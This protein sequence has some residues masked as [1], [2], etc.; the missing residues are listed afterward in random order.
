MAILSGLSA[1]HCYDLC[2]V[3]TGPVG[4]SMALEARARGAR[5]LLLE[6]GTSE[7]DDTGQEHVRAHIADAQRHAPMEIATQRGLGGGSWLWGGRCVPFEPID[8]APRDFVPGSGW[9][10]GL[11]ELLPWYPAAAQFLDCSKALFRS[12]SDWPA[13]PEI[14]LSQLE[15]WS[16]QPKLAPKLGGWALATPG[17]DILCDATV[18]GLDL[19]PQADGG[20]HLRGLQV[21]HVDQAIEVH[22]GDYVLA[23]GGLETTRLLLA[24]QARRAQDMPGLFGGQGGPLGGYY[25]GHIFG[26]IGSLVLTKPKSFTALDFSLDQT[27]TYVR[28]R[29]TL[30]ERVQRERQLLNTSFFADNPPFYDERHRNPTLSLVFLALSVP[31]LGRRLLSEAIRLKHIG[32]PP[33]R[34]GAHMLNVLRRPWRAV[35][36]VFD[37]LHLRYLS[38]TRKPGFVLRNEGG[39][40][41]LNYHAE[42]LPNPDSRVTLAKQQDAYGR[43]RLHID[44]RY[45]PADAESV[46]R[47]HEVLD[48]NLRAAGM[49]H[50]AY[51]RPPEQRLDHILEQASD[52]FHQTGTTRMSADPG[53]GVVDR[54]GAVH[55]VAHL[56]VASSSNFP[57]TGEA[58]PTFLAVAMGVRLAARLA[59]GAQERSAIPSFYPFP[60]PTSGQDNPPIPPMKKITIPGTVLAVSRFSFGTASLHHLF[61]QEQRLALLRA[62]I[63]AGFTHFDTSPYYGFGLAEQSLGQLS[64]SELQGITIATKVGLYGPSGSSPQVPDILLRKVAGKFIKS[65]NQPVVDWSLAR[66]RASLEQS[67][68]R[69]R[70]GHVDILY[71][72]E[73]VAELIASDEWQRWLESLVLAGKIRYW[74]I[75]GEAAAIAAMLEQSPGLTQLVQ[76]RD[77]LSLHQA[78]LLQAHQRPLQ[79]TYGYMTDAA[80]RAVPAP[81]KLTQALARNASGSIIVS[82]R[83]LERVAQLASLP[84]LAGE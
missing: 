13:M 12:P 43:P 39:T 34:Y 42:Q 77:S 11:D 10:I 57:T 76:V 80:T 67:L 14:E 31:L 41:A 20:I 82:T 35:A 53:A 72:H 68:R 55:G 26:S 17:I 16:Q 83:K 58:N 21:R 50:V 6:S 33:Y 49:G 1:D 48:Q 5:V 30:T 18:T 28:R 79:F 81:V 40:Y 78:D 36:D 24:E 52:G 3:G 19:I 9:P 15:R 37:I 25:M 59:G 70:R 56:H 62:A 32:P 23:C 38:P 45:L 84:G 2:I 63:D 44:F 61:R 47:A 29:F 65:L 71:L 22:A 4:L 8:F 69:L 51:H 7:C 54:N 74:G 27:G 60:L 73:P 66:A 46:L 64:A 75:A